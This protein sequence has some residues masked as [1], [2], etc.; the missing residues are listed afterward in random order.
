MES[1]RILVVADD[2]AAAATI[3]EQLIQLG[4]AAPLLAA[5]GTEALACA[6]ENQPDVVLMDVMLKSD[7]D[8]IATA[9][10][11]RTQ[12]NAAVIFLS[13]FIDD[14]SIARVQVAEPFGWLSQP[15]RASEIDAVIKSA[16]ARRAAEQAAGVHETI[17]PLIEEPPVSRP[18]H[19]PA[20][21][22]QSALEAILA[23]LKV[24]DDLDK[25]L[26]NVLA[27]AVP[28]LEC[29]TAAISLCQNNRWHISYVYGMPAEVIGTEMN[30]DEERHAR[31]AIATQQIVSIE[32]AWAD[33]R[34]NREHLRKWNIGAV[35]VV[36]LLAGKDTLGVI[37]FNYHNRTF[38]FQRAH[39]NFAR[40][41]MNALSLALDN[42]RL[43]ESLRSALA[44]RQRAMVALRQS[45]ELFS[46]AFHSSP[47]AMCVSRAADGKLFDINHQY[48]RLFGFARE[49]ILGK[50][51]L[52]LN[53]YLDPA[54]RARL[55]ERMRAEGHLVD[56]ELTERKK[57]GDLIH[58]LIN[59]EPLEIA[60]EACLVAAIIDITERKRVEDEL[61]F[62]ASLID[63]ISEA[64]I[65]TDLQFNITRWNRAAQEMYGWHVEQVLGKSADELLKSEYLN[66]L[67]HAESLRLLRERGYWRGELVQ[68]KKDGTP[69]HIV[70]SV[71][72]VLNAEGQTVGYIAINR[73]LT[74]RRQM[75][76]ALKKSEEKYA[77]LFHRAAVPAVLTNLPART[78]ADVNE[79]F[80]KLSGW[81]RAELLDKTSADLGMTIPA[82]QARDVAD[83][84][85]FGEVRE[86]EKI[87]ITKTG[88]PRVVSVNINR[89]EFGGQLYAITTM[90]DITERK[91]QEAQLRELSQ[92]LTYHVDHSPLAVIE[93][94]ADM[95]LV[96]W[97]G[98]AERIFGWQAQEVLGKR[99]EDFRWVY[100]EDI[101]QV[102]EV[103]ADLQTGKKRKSFSANR[104][105]RKDGLI[106]YCEWY[107]SALLDESGKLRS[108]LS[109]V[110]DV[111]ER[112]KAER[113]LAESE[114]RFRMTLANSPI[115]VF[116]QDRDL[117][118]TWAYNPT[119]DLTVEAILGKT[120]AELIAP[121]EAARLTAIKRPVLDTG[122]PARA[123]APITI[124]GAQRIFDLS[125]EPLRDERG[126]IMGI[127]CVAID[128][129][130]QRRA[131]QQIAYQ[132]KLL[133]QV[134]DA[135]VA[136]DAEYRI[137][138]WNA[139][140]EKM[141]GWTA[142]EILG[143]KGI[144][145]LKTEWREGDAETM[146]RKIATLGEWRGEVTQVR[147]NGVRFPVEISSS[148]IRDNE[149][150][151]TGYVS[152]NRDITQR[153]IMEA[154]LLAQAKR[155][156]ALVDIAQSVSFPDANLQ[157]VLD[158]IAEHAGGALGAQCL[159]A[160]LTEDG[161]WFK[162]VSYYAPGHP[163][164]VPRGEMP[165]APLPISNSFVE[166]VIQ[167]GQVGHFIGRSPT[168]LDA[169]LKP[170]YQNLI[171]TF[172]T[173]T[174]I[175]APMRVRGNIVGLVTIAG[176]PTDALPLEVEAFVQEVADRAAIAF[177]AAHFIQQERATRLAFD[178]Q[179][180]A[181]VRAEA[182]L[183]TSRA[184]HQSLDVSQVLV[185]FLDG[186]AQFV[187]Y[188]SASV[189]LLDRAGNLELRAARGAGEE[190][191]VPITLPRR[192]IPVLNQLIA[193]RTSRRIDDV[194]TT[195]EWIDLP[196]A[197]EMNNWLGVP[198]MI[199]QQVIGVCSLHKIEPGSF[200]E[201]H[202]RTTE[203]LAASA[204]IALQNAQAYSRASALEPVH[205][206]ARRT[207]QPNSHR[208]KVT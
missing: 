37:F 173:D 156:A 128:I 151:I 51:P 3:Q 186:L 112:H 27:V 88:E 166:Q 179:K 89:V 43:T 177:A 205:S 66:G 61:R 155:N 85:Q 42:V 117:R 12:Y 126:D 75:E 23:A 141:Y 36:P 98:E 203:S 76:Q 62:H 135:I 159:I 48:L 184:M 102:A 26:P 168:E 77:V 119:E 14:E 136:S 47:I 1:V 191:P 92:R 123:Q 149:G 104:N 140:A 194:K 108:I 206:P 97:S 120:D 121:D 30:D 63:N 52:E 40:Q 172:H 68:R 16:L 80:E 101:P 31:L 29:D 106:A 13:R 174:L 4:Y 171:N 200:T 56:Y 20:N 83:L 180:Q 11:L 148:V 96:R 94:G 78:F 187:S 45:E 7:I 152:V 127:A 145:W 93:F 8:S 131:Q 164:A 10:T 59:I 188:D 124:N 114:H 32:D 160:L 198:L 64:A 79:A 189:M 86:R 72:P 2:S 38:E 175:V 21:Q 84:Q 197:E 146:R 69:M 170:A 178:R 53:M 39:L 129:T 118:Y 204:V 110:L 95:R 183:E 207:R 169:A 91:R 5:T 44:E 132:A 25:S 105:Y 71:A 99:V 18:T 111:T 139:A 195:L 193:S 185:A 125:V 28:V 176:Q 201:E 82:E 153:K 154:H 9:F 54:D 137:T 109:L 24:S 196:N 147:K 144:D 70:S 33:A 87:L 157:Y 46:K 142:A 122:V 162:P 138:A 133:A 107:N 50:S 90:D 74:Q 115:T 130:E 116:N 199:D 143:Q 134:N 49:E 60:G 35:L 15:Y 161:G 190:M 208:R 163:R 202:L 167:T 19:P 81:T 192:T 100:E 34:V 55:L 17:L 113:A 73:D 41:L 182:L 158:S 150:R 181:T 6:A 22:W 57:S 65:A 67:S 58:I 165:F 103:S